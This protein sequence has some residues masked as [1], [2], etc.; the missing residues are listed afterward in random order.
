MTICF[1]SAQ[2]LPTVGGVERYTYNLARRVIA[3]G[4]K[5]LVVTSALP[6]LPDHETDAEGIEIIRLPVWP[7]MGGR[8]PVLRPGR[9]FARLEKLLWD[10]KIDFC[11][12]NTRFYV[13]SLYAA[14]EAAK[15]HIP[16]IVVDHSTGH[17]PMNS[18][19]LNT[20]GAAYEHFAAAV[21][22]AYH[23]RFYGVSRAVCR[24]LEHFGIKA[25]GQLYNAVDPAEVRAL[26][27][28]PDAIDWRKELGLAPDAP[29]AAFVGRIIPEKGVAELIEAFTAA[30]VPGAALAVAGDGP[31]LATLRKDCPPGVYLLGA[32]AYPKAMQLLAQSQVYCLPTYYAEGFPTTFLEAAAC[33]CP[34]VTTRTG[35]SDEL[36]ADETYGI[37]LDSADADPLAAALGRALTDEDWR[38]T[39]AAKTAARLEEHFTWDAVCDRL[40]KLTAA[41]N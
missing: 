40:L 8:F 14:R 9:D 39:A 12:I 35:G 4:H 6:G 5:A 1:F 30:A 11:L 18:A 15:R 3:A 24:W 25:E 20:A 37:Q 32:V 28:A 29:L 13:S 16:A 17:L 27:Q 41:Q 10:R 34:I 21:L 38:R 7:L 2:Y 31:L 36:L 33:G 22:K 26:A 19:L 23:M